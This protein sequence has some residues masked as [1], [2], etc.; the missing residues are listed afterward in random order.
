MKDGEP[1]TGGVL[2][3]PLSQESSV[4]HETLQSSIGNNIP[5]TLMDNR[6]DSVN[7]YS[8]SHRRSYYVDE[9][10][11]KVLLLVRDVKKQV[12]ILMSTRTTHPS[13]NDVPPEVEEDLA[14]L[15]SLELKIQQCYKGDI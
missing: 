15:K 11:N 1:L 14:V 9:E 7:F 2:D 6:K 4:S 8:S 3:M 10:I 12:E 13:S 5:I